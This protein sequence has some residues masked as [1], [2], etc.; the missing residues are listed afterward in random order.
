VVIGISLV[1][2]AAFALSYML[3]LDRQLAQALPPSAGVRVVDLHPL[4]STDPRGLSAFYVT[5]AAT[6]LG[7][8][9]VFQLR[10]NAPG[11]G[12]RDWLVLLMLLAVSSGLVLALVSECVSKLDGRPRRGSG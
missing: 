3:A 2:G 10:A 11:T 8:V 1:M 4:P 12:L 9:P 6:I 5:I 7:F